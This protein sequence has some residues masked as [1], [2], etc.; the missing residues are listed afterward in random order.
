MTLAIA[1]P[2]LP[3][4]LL[5]LASQ[6]EMQPRFAAN[7]VLFA[8]WYAPCHGLIAWPEEVKSIQEVERKRQLSFERISSLLSKMNYAFESASRDLEYA[9]LLLE[10]IAVHEWVARQ[11]TE[12]STLIGK[13]SGGLEHFYEHLTQGAQ[14]AFSDRLEELANQ[15][16][17]SPLEAELLAFGAAYTASEEVRTIFG[18][19]DS[20]RGLAPSVFAR[21]FNVSLGQ[22]TEALSEKSPLR[23]SGLL[24]TRGRF[25]RFPVLSEFWLR[26]LA[27]AENGLAA[28]LT[29]PMK[30]KATSGMPARLDPEDAELAANVLSNAPASPGVNL[31]LY[32]AGGL[33][34][35][36]VLQD[37]VKRTGLTPYRLAQL[38]GM[39]PEAAAMA[40]VAQ[41]CLV[42]YDPNAVL[43]LDRPADVLE[44]GAGAT[45]ARLFGLDIEPANDSRTEAMLLANPVPTIWLASDVASLGADTV[46]RFVFHARLQKARR[47]DRRAYLEQVVRALDVSPGTQDELLALEDVSAIQLD[48]GLRA[49][50]LSGAQDQEGLEAALVQA[51]RRG[52][53]ALERS[54]QA[55]AKECVT[56]YSLDFLNCA[57]RFRPDQILKALQQ[58]PRGS[59][60]LYGLPGTG[61]TQFVEHV[62]QVLGKKL[63]AKRAS[64]LLSK[65]V[66]ESEQNIAA[67][68]E[69]ASSEDAILFLDEADSL[70]GDRSRAQASWEVSKVNE[71]LQHMERFDGIF[72]VSTNLFEGLDSA[73]LRRFTFKLKFESLSADQRWEMFLNE[74]GLRQAEPQQVEQHREAL[75]ES[76]WLLRDLCAGDFATV[77][78]QCV[79]LGEALSPQEWFEQLRLECEAKSRAY[80]HGGSRQVH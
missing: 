40:Y 61:K 56:K 60:C 73:A 29:E 27:E 6:A 20:S 48:A 2:Q 45:L 71:L 76:L 36:G 53:R 63:L 68:F 1:I 22:L 37:L 69:E 9:R 39:R 75:Q 8:A 3:F 25:I 44:T 31:L 80:G 52:L 55:Q 58:R 17:L 79:L 35:Q 23:L 21:I 72:F 49:A 33:D 19:L 30:F 28:A 74:T 65:W 26:L 34:K 18:Q 57:G 64:D 24:T 38:E 15:L 77:K 4:W 13:T 62:A 46:A 42:G 10:G 5:R 41:R 70:L 7:A 54:T 66:G 12:F 59:V 47:E 14:N 11:A 32:G 43:V 51:V 16:G 78:R 67:M 50:R